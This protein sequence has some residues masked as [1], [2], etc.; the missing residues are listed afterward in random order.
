[1]TASAKLPNHAILSAEERAM[2][3]QY[4]TD[5]EYKPFAQVASETGLHP[6]ILC[7]LV[8]DG[9]L[10]GAIG[11]SSSQ[12]GMCNV[13]QAREIAA[14]LDA[15]RTPVEG[16]PIT[17]QDA[18]DK[19]GFDSKSIYNWHNK[20]WIEKLSGDRRNRLF[21]EGDIAFAR[22]LADLRGQGAG[23]SVF[24]A[25]SRSGRPRKQ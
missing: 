6:D 18:T 12:A 1:M 4:I 7:M 5:V 2:L 13:E 8:R 11:A 17:A 20:G 10:D 19:Y 3:A 15:A 9:L 22:A 14:Q 21:N 25:K 23:K 24:P 16:R